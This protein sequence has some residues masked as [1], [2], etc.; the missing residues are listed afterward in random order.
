MPGHV[1]LIEDEANIAEALVVED[2]VV[3]PPDFDAK[4]DTIRGYMDECNADMFSG[5]IVD[6]HRDAVVSGVERRD[7]LCMVQ[8]DRAVM[9]ICNLYR[10][11][12]IDHMANWD[13]QDDNAFSNTIDRYME[14]ATH[15]RVVTTLP[16]MVD[17]GA[18]LPSTLREADNH[19]FDALRA[20][21]EALLAEKVAAFEA[22]HRD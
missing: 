15:L 19:K 18:N 3:L 14:Q 13:D 2:D 4:L 16:F 12:M 20:R 9:T 7:G 11:R 8:L 5:L 1:M 17:Y 10:A 6:L 22:S 21:S